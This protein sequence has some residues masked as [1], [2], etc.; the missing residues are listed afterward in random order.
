MPALHGPTILASRPTHGQHP[1]EPSDDTPPPAAAMA[2]SWILL[3]S[4]DC[5]LPPATYKTAAEARTSTD[6]RLCVAFDLAAPPASSVLH[7][8]CMEATRV[9]KYGSG[10]N[11]ITAHGDSVL[12]R[13]RRDRNPPPPD[14]PCDHFVYRAGG[15]GRPPS[16]SLLPLLKGMEK[17]EEGV[18]DPNFRPLLDH[19][20]GI[21][22]SG[23][24]ELLVPRIELLIED[25]EGRRMAHLCVLRPGMSQWEHKPKIGVNTDDSFVAD[26]KT[27]AYSCTYTGENLRVSFG[28]APP[29]ASSFFHYDFPE[30]TSSREDI[31][32]NAEECEE[33]GDYTDECEEE[34]DSDDECEEQEWELVEPVPIIRDEGGKD[35]EQLHTQC[36]RNTVIPLGDR[37]LCW[38]KYISGFLLC[39]MEDEESPKVRYVPLPPGVCWD[40]KGYERDMSIKHSKNMGAVGPSAVGFVSIDPRCCC[41]GTGKSTC[42]HSRYAFTI[43]TWLMDINSIKEPLT[44]VKDGEIDCEE[45][46]RLPGYEGLP[47]ANPM[48]PIVCLDNPDVVCFLVSNNAFVSSYDYED[49]KRWMIQLNIK[50]KQL[51]VVPYNDDRR[52]A[53]DHLPV[54]LHSSAANAGLKFTAVQ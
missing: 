52:G 44:W 45:L 48:C 29:P 37:F 51:S 32:D 13:M 15:V 38:V 24:N 9:E 50:T 2:P 1:T 21:L 5:P 23:D 3:H 35:I 34:G 16:L 22:R 41:G 54:T 47:R 31:D 49:R 46:W 14:V 19:D 4:H 8:E 20:T 53:Y 7:Y 10:L 28:R 36:G 17:Y 27:V 26:A 6:Q 43:N 12:L 30:S 40:P 18:E 33:D 11:I 39:D 42:S 25:Y